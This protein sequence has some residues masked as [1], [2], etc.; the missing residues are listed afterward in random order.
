MSSRQRILAIRLGAMGDI[1]H[2][3]PA[4]AS[5][6]RGYPDAHLSWIVEPKWKPLLDGCPFVDEVISFDRSSGSATFA[7]WR[8]LGEHPFEHGVAGRFTGDGEPFQNG[9]TAGDQSA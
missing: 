8:S 1:F 7:A 4:V 3:M 9:N 2:A 6:R 5:L